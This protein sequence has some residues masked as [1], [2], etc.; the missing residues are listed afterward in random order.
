MRYPPSR[1]ELRLHYDEHDWFIPVPIGFWPEELAA[2]NIVALDFHGRPEVR[3]MVTEVFRYEPL[4]ERRSFVM[5]VGPDP[6]EGEPDVTFEFT[7]PEEES[8]P[9]W[10]GLG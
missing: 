6:V 2:G 9:T 10:P 5:R 1:E 4:E 8:W 7:P 3:G